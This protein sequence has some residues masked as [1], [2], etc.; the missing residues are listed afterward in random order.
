LDAVCDVDNDCETPGEYLVRS[1]CP[2]T[3]KCI[4]GKCNVVCPAFDGKKYEDVRECGECPMLSTPGP[5]FCLD[6]Q[7]ESGRV[8]ECGCNLPPKCNRGCTE[9]AKVCPDETTVSRV[10]PDCEFE[11]CPGLVACT[12]D[13]RIC[14]DGSAVGREG[15]D[16]EFAPCKT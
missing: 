16:C 13:A 7:I 3:S 9:E 5:N 14:P 1:N 10:G 2:F 11:E 12:M 15:P 8:D 6:G 4:K